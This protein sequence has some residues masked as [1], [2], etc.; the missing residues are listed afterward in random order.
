[1]ESNIPN[2][3]PV[4][5]KVYGEIGRRFRSFLD[6][7]EM[8]V[9]IGEALWVQYGLR[10]GRGSGEGA[11]AVTDKSLIFILNRDSQSIKIP[12][13]DILNIWKS[14][15]IMPNFSEIH[16]KTRNGEEFSFYA[17]KRMCKEIIGLGIV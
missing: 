4:S 7:G 8:I 6:S 1:M 9:T 12:R 14:F 16:F 2:G 15:I 3:S 5:K 10:N 13:A 11:L 17:T